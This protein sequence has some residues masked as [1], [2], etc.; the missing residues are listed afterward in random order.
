[1]F[2]TWL[3]CI[4]YFIGSYYITVVIFDKLKERDE[5]DLAQLESQ[6]QNM[7]LNTTQSLNQAV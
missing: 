2:L 7:T 5:A 6:L 1:M 3:M 4:G